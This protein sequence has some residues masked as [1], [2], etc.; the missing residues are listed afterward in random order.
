MSSDVRATTAKERKAKK[1]VSHLE[2]RP[3]MSGGH[4]VETH[5]TASYDHPPA[6]KEFAGPH[7]AVALPKG[8]VL[9][10]ISQEMGIPTKVGTQSAGSEENVEEKESNEL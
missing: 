4:N 10:H 3:N 1:V 8:H 7:A 6:I 9:H 5:H 2:V